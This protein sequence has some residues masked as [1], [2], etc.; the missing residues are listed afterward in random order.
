MLPKYP[1]KIEAVKASV[2]QHGFVFNIANCLEDGITYSEKQE[3]TILH[4]AGLHHMGAPEI[5]FLLGPRKGERHSQETSANLLNDIVY[6]VHGEEIDMILRQRTT[7]LSIGTSYRRRHY[8]LRFFHSL[9]Q[10]IHFKE[11]YL[12]DLAHI[13]E[14]PDFGIM[15]FEPGRWVS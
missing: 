14:S 6:T 4:T 7:A 1:D 10:E 3:D 5:I 12:V 11:T 15:V 8:K 13:L 2:K 9:A